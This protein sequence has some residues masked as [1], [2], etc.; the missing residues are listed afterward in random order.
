M[1]KAQRYSNNALCSREL[2]ERVMREERE[3]ASSPG[4]VKALSLSLSL[5]VWKCWSN[6]SFRLDS[7][8]LLSAS[9]RLPLSLSLSLSVSLS[10][11]SYR[12]VDPSSPDIRTAVAGNGVD[13]LEAKASSAARRGIGGTIEDLQTRSS[14]SLFLSLRLASQPTAFLY[15]CLFCPQF[16]LF[17]S[18]RSGAAR[19]FCAK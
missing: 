14:L 6:I 18:L 13:R 3:P 2:R 5:S 8:I 10:H 19:V 16:S 4:S 11:S 15:S 7:A 9:R 12:A 17:F 1:E